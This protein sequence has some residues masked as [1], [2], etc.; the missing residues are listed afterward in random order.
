MNLNECLLKN[1]QKPCKED[2]S[3]S[4]VDLRHPQIQN[5][6]V[7]KNNLSKNETIDAA[8]RLHTVVIFFSFFLY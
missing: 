2:I 7:L 4:I 6:H 8:K 5:V 1:Q 3:I